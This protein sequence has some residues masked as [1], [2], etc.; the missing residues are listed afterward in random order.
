MLALF[1][2]LIKKLQDIIPFK[3]PF[4]FIV[5]NLSILVAWYNFLIGKRFVIWEPTKR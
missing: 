2:F 4:F 1:A 5:V 3:I